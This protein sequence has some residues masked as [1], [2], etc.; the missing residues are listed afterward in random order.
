M[1]IFVIDTVCSQL[2]GHNLSAL[3]NHKKIFS[4]LM[5][6]THEIHCLGSKVLKDTCDETSFENV[7]PYFEFCYYDVLPLATADDKSFC[8]IK[9]DY[10]TP[11]DPHYQLRIKSPLIS[12]Y[13]KY[14]SKVKELSD[15][16]FE[17]FFKEYNICKDDIIY[18]PSVDYYSSISIMKCMSKLPF[19]KSPS[20]CMR[21]INVMEQWTTLSEEPL[22][23]ILNF[24]N[25]LKSRGYKTFLATESIGYSYYLSKLSKIDVFQLSYPPNPEITHFPPQSE[26]KRVLFPGSQRSDKGM[27]RIPDIIRNYINNYDYEDVEFVVQLPGIQNMLGSIPVYRQLSAWPMVI[28]QES[29]VTSAQIAENYKSATCICLPYCEKTYS[30][31]RSSASLVEAIYSG[32]PLIASRCE[33]FASEIEFFNFGRVEGSDESIARSIN[34]FLAL[35]PSDLHSQIKQSI[36]RYNQFLMGSYNYALKKMVD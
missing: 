18:F 28:I 1:R 4:D 29:T 33:G 8:P 9:F 24:S 6:K 2:K 5:G 27:S 13:K 22:I 26:K 19:K 14:H 23:D 25:L 30:S 34:H 3:N 7:T 16:D 12:K 15:N 21:F 20:L 31:L 11:I 10:E 36:H 17:K 35:D 32:R